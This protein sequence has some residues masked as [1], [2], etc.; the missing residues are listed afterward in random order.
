MASRETLF[1]KANV[2]SQLNR[3]LTQL[4]DIEDSK[5][6]LDDSEYNEMKSQTIAD[7]SVFETSLR[8]LME[9]DVTL[10]DQLSSVQMAIQAAIRQAFKTPEVIRMF[11]RKEPVALRSRLGNIEGDRRLG[12]ISEESYNIQASEIL[13]ALQ[14]LG[15]VVCDLNASFEFY[16]SYLLLNEIC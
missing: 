15:E 16:I 1:L 12:R 9:G 2:E 11:A 14:N 10:V 13:L 5:A 4:Q 8:R 7:L 6:D 3:L